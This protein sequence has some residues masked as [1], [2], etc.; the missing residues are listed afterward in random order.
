MTQHIDDIPRDKL[1]VLS[2]DSCNHTVAPKAQFNH[3]CGT[4]IHGDGR[5]VYT[6]PD[7][8]D[9]EIF[10]GHL[11]ASEIERMFALL[12]AK[13]FFVLADRYAEHIAGG[14][15]TIITATRP[16]KPTKSVACYRPHAAPPGFREC[17][18]ALRHPAFH[19][20][21]IKAYV[22]Q[23]ITA[24]DLAQGWYWGME[25]QKK[26]D[27][28]NDW[29]WLEAGKSSKW[30]RP[31]HHTVT[32]D[33]SYMMPPLANC[34]HVSVHYTNDPAASGS[35]IQFDRNTMSPNAFG[36]IG[37]STKMYFTP[38]PATYTL[39]DTTGDERLFGVSVP[40]YI[41]AN[42]RLVV[43]GDLARPTGGRLLEVDDHGAIHGIHWMQPVTPA[44]S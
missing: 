33:S 13:G 27:T 36:E 37:I 20:A 26:L 29:I 22:R 17:Y 43:I 2:A 32:L 5:V 19:P 16:G 4:Q 15:T 41:G 18:A 44:A 23:P 38:Q 34:R 3:I 31:M 25:Y 42:L 28:P 9:A 24:A 10:E 21:G 40:G 11:D 8:G 39:L 35:M 6:D 1:V 14:T 30:I 7:K 12:D